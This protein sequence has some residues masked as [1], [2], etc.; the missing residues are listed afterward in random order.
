MNDLAKKHMPGGKRTPD[1]KPVPRVTAW[2]E[3]PVFAEQ[4]GKDLLNWIRQDTP[5]GITRTPEDRLPNGLASGMMA[6]LV[7]WD[8][9]NPDDP[10]NG[11]F[12]VHNVIVGGNVVLGQLVHA[13]IRIPTRSIID[14][15]Y[16][17]VKP[18]LTGLGKN[19]GHAQL[20]FVFDPNN[21]PKILGTEADKLLSDPY[22]DDLIMSWEAWRPPLVKWDFE[23]GLDASNFTL[24]ARMLAGHMR[25]ANDSLRK[26]IWHCY[27]LALPDVDDAADTLLHTALLMGDSLMRRVIG[28]MIDLDKLHSTTLPKGEQWTAK[29]VEKARKALGRE[30]I[31][32]ED[33]KTDF[34]DIDISYQLFERSCITQT[35]TEVEMAM[36]WIHTKHNLGHREQVRISPESFPPFFDCI[37]KGDRKGMIAGIPEGLS[38]FRKHSTVAPGKSYQLL[39]EAGLLQQDENGQ[40]ISYAYDIERITPYGKLGHNLMS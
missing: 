31:P 2:H 17:V 28:E 13:T 22:L 19:G 10:E 4:S 38:W 15:E 36:Q 29:E 26:N 30:Q 35:M 27:P 5:I 6:I 40:T 33:A 39:E 34:S 20:R 37:I 14:V 24:T 7:D 12:I 3:N 21:R 32:D 11:C 25:F 8:A 16:V 18:S 23:T 1:G 9:S